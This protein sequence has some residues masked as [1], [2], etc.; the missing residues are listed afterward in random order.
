MLFRPVYIKETKI[1]TQSK[2]KK[3]V[4]Q[5]T[6]NTSEQATS[7][8]KPETDSNT[9]EPPPR[10]PMLVSNEFG[11]KIVIPKEAT[12]DVISGK[13]PYYLVDE[14]G[15]TLFE[16]KHVLV[17]L[18]LDDEHRRRIQ[19]FPCIGAHLRELPFRPRKI[20]YRRRYISPE[21]IG[22]GIYGPYANNSHDDGAGPSTM[23]SSAYY[24][25]FSR[26]GA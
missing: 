16:P 20:K 7:S 25:D 12:R 21:L 15:M 18:K 17:A 9:E 2:Q 1:N 22:K 26:P 11:F 24:S 8:H 5:K 3:P 19:D 4:M 13:V 23:T 10:I 14:N 6:V